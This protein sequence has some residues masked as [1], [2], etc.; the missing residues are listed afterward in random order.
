MLRQEDMGERVES[1]Q[2]V[3]TIAT[4]RYNKSAVIRTCIS[5]IFTSSYESAF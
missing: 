4:T 1:V 3:E 2:S 5:S